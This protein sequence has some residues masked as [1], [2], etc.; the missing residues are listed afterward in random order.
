MS[1][2]S[3][4]KERNPKKTELLI[5]VQKVENTVTVGKCRMPLKTFF[6]HLKEA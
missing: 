1:I 3:F 2:F 5:E 4:P 6:L